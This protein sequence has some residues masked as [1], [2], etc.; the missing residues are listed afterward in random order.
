MYKEVVKLVRVDRDKER[1]SNSSV[2]LT[3]LQYKG[4]PLEYGVRM[5]EFPQEFRMDN[6]I[7]AG[8]IS[9]NTIDRH[10]SEQ[11][12]LFF[13]QKMKQTTKKENGLKKN[14]RIFL[15]WQNH[16]CKCIKSSNGL[17]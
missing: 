10:V 12:Y 8:K 4:K 9:L 13:V 2:K 7:T 11:K 3:N 6:L 16:T 15:N 1:G 5:L 17:Y 14:Q